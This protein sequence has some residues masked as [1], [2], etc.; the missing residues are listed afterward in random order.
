[1]LDRD[2][3]VRNTDLARAYYMLGMTQ[4]AYSKALSAVKKDPLNSSAH[5]FLSNEY[6]STGQWLGAAD[7]EFLLYKLLSPANENTFSLYTDYTQMFEMPY[8]RLSLT[9]GAGAWA[10]HQVPLQSYSIEALG[11]LPGLALDAFGSYQ[12]D[13]GYRKANDDMTYYFADVMGKYEPTIKDSFY[14]NYTYD[15]AAWGDT[16]Y[17]D[18]YSYVNDK[19]LR[20]TAIENSAEG[21]FV[22]RFTPEAVF[23]GYFN[24]GK[25]D[26]VKTGSSF[27]FFNNGFWNAVFENYHEPIVWE[28]NNLQ[29]QQQLKLGD[30]TFIGGVQYINGSYYSNYKATGIE[31]TFFPFGIS[32]GPYSYDSE[33]NPPDRSTSFYVHDYWRICPQLLVELGVSGDF[34]RSYRELYPYSVS[35]TTVNPSVGLNYEIDKSNTLRLAYQ[36]YVN[37][38]KTATSSTLAPSEVAGFPSLINADQGSQIKELGFSWESQ[39]NPKTF[40]V[41]HMQAYRIE[42]PQFDLHSS[43]YQDRTESAG[44]SFTLNRLLTT[45]LGLSAGISGSATSMASPHP[46][47]LL[48]TGCYSE[49]AGKVGLFYMHPKGWFA[50]INDTVV[51]QNLEGLSNSSLAKQQGQ[52]GNPFNLVD[53]GFGKYF[54]NKRGYAA[55]AVTNVFNQHF[56]YQTE[57]YA[58]WNFYPDREIMFTMALYF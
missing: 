46:E 10:D 40:T 25:W 37:S 57:P 52:L 53:I 20:T 4:W 11:G 21:G 55:L 50:S 5:L 33:L 42:D 30:H 18:N 45:S 43:P 8:T 24:W 35:S 15:K 48:T 19:T 16:L 41:L 13:P 38:L 22:H 3:A 7:S 14:A 26:W 36:G 47:D 51:S 44:G 17:P 58:L 56:Y 31:D 28:S 27:F 2:L 9:A 29:I 32:V 49:I 1:M 34:V 23:I 39:W 12:R 54:D 6:S